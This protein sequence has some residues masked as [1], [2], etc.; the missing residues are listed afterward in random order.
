MRSIRNK[1]K[2]SKIMKW[3]NNIVTAILMTL[4][5][6]VAFIVVIS[7]ASG[8]EPQFFGYQ[9]KTVLS[10][11]MEPDIQTGSIIAV[12][13]AEDK[14]SY[15]A[16]DVITFQEAED[17]LVTHRI[18][19][20]VS[21]GDSVLYRTKGDNNNAEDMNPVM[22]ENVVAQYTGFTLPYVGYFNNFASS[23]NGAFLL[24][25][26]GLLLLLYSAF[27]LWKALALIEIPLRKQDEVI[28]EDNAKSTS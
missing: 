1:A 17:F 25:I 19:E 18:T 5:I 20:V 16:G 26:P 23:K 10:G 22:A 6:S 21:N 13:L 12:K 28:A 4:L 2:N 24:I 15:K 8:G 27:T 14:T 7:K 3:V 9:L 11:S